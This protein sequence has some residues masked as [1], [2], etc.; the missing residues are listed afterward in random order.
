MQIDWLTVIA[1]IVNFLVLVWL[2]RRFL[3]RPVIEAMERREKRIADRLQEADQREHAA[4]IK[5]QEYESKRLQLE[6]T[7]QQRLSEAEAAA[8]EKRKSLLEEARKETDEQ[9]RQWQAQLE[10]EQQDFLKG[11]RNYSVEAIQ[12]IG[13]RTLADL[14]NSD[15]EAQIAQV[16]LQRLKSLDDTTRKALQR[17]QGPILVISAFDLDAGTKG[18]ITCAIHEQIGESAEV[19]YDQSTDLLCGVVL[20]TGGH[21]I[22]WTLADYL[23]GLDERMEKALQSR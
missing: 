16:F 4:G 3:Y 22:G 13:R 1:Q 8:E 10:R 17:T 18:D 15:L 2:L 21:Q 20:K 6:Q 9:R 5:A 7:R 12:Q 11:L 23:D 19:E 14:A